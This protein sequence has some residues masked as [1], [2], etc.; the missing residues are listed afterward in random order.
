[1]AR[2]GEDRWQPPARVAALMPEISGNSINGL[3]ETKERPPTPIM[4]HRPDRIA[5]GAIQSLVNERYESHPDLKGIFG[6]PE[7]MAK[8]A[9]IAETR[10]D[11]TPENW[12]R[13]VKEFALANHADLV[14]V[15]RVNPNW[16]F[17]G[18]TVESPWVVMLA[19]AM[20]HSE[21]ATAPETAAA[22]EVARQ[23][24][25]GTIAAR[26]LANWIRG[27]GY[28]AEGH[29]GPYAGPMSLLPAALAA[30]FGELGKH[31]SIINDTY[32]SSF[33]IAGVITDLPLVADAPTEFGADDFCTSCQV[34][35]T[36]CPP[37]A[38]FR[39]KQTVRGRTKWYVDFDLCMPYFAEN[40]GCGICIA[41]CPWS[42]PG[43]APRLA[44]KMMLRRARKAEDVA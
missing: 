4:W 14:G 43:T 35:T 12:T 16:V 27:Q 36:A 20:D 5:H 29:G 10:A 15:A 11:D 30:G 3:E 22:V 7:R 31:G 40:Y 17:E 18:F 21:L 1:M 33:R 26:A 2:K 24:N 34:C 32:G 44:E 23:Y 9:P 42:K 19:V 38:I 37:D 41:V 39:E 25:R 8:P 28:E 6:I 13:R